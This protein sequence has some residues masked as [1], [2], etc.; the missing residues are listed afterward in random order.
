MHQLLIDF[1]KTYDLVRREV[2]YNILTEFRIPMNLVTV[3]KMCLN[4]TSSDVCTGKYLPDAF[5]VQ[6]SLKQDV[7]SL[8]LSYFALEYAIRK[9]QENQK[10][11]RIQWYTSATGLC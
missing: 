1:E 7:L 8:L 5:A 4:K 3:I 6:H 2:L 9:I 10:R 11:S